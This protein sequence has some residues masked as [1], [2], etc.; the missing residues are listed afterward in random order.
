VHVLYIK[1]NPNNEINYFLGYYTQMHIF[2]ILA[3]VAVP[4]TQ[5]LSVE[6]ADRNWI[7]AMFALISFKAVQMT[8]SRFQNQL[9]SLYDVNTADLNTN[10]HNN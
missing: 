3:M 6:S 8:L 9:A 4:D 2:E 10:G 1:S 7:Q 5:P